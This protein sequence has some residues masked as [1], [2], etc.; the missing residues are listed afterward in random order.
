MLERIGVSDI[1]ELFSEIPEAVKN[2]AGYNL[3]PA[4]SNELRRPARELAA[5]NKPLI[6]FCGAGAYDVY[7]PAIIRILHRDRSS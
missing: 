5:K 2:R 6:S 1:D 3:E 7:T 4:F